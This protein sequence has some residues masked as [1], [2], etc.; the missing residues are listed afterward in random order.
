MSDISADDAAF[1]ETALAA[2]PTPAAPEKLNV[3]LPAVP[4]PLTLIFGVVATGEDGSGPPIL[5]LTAVNDSGSMTQ[6][7]MEP[8]NAMKVGRDLLGAARSALVR[9]PP[10]LYAADGQSPLVS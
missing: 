2:E 5:V 7:Y 9:R 1:I 3:P 10:K 6:G 4:L 8:E